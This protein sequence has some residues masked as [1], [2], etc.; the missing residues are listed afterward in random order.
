MN[1]I[2]EMRNEAATLRAISPYDYEPTANTMEEWAAEVETLIAERDKYKLFYDAIIDRAVVDWTYTAEDE[3]DPR[4]AVAKL[5][6]NYIALAADP[7]ICENTARLAAMA[8]AAESR[9]ADATKKIRDLRGDPPCQCAPRYNVCRCKAKTDTHDLIR[10]EALD[11]A[12]EIAEG[13]D[14]A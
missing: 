4:K 3:T 6:A 9:L 12:I 7:Q 1:I 5:V 14:D 11:D 13:R 10:Y 2:D 8:E